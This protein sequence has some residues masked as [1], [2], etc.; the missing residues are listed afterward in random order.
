VQSSSDLVPR[1]LLF[2]RLKLGYWRRNIGDTAHMI[3]AI[4]DSV[5]IGVRR[6]LSKACYLR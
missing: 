4:R 5:T 3:G 2:R 1:G 6:G